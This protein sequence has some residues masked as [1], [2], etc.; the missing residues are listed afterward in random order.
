MFSFTSIKDYHADILHG[1]TTCV[2]AVQYFLQQIDNNKHLNAFVEVFAAEALEQ[3]KK[4]DITFLKNG[5][6]GKM[7]GVVVGLKDVICYKDHQVSAGSKIL[8]GFTAVYNATVVE[9]LL[10]EGC[11][12][13]WPPKLR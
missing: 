12:H 11:Y 3:A 1:R 2:E 7:H 4:L 9:R 8:E 13:H 5:M 10:H 6:Y